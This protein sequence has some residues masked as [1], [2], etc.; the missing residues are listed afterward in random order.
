MQIIVSYRGVTHVHGFETGACLSRA[1]RRL[2][3][4]VYEYGKFYDYKLENPLELSLCKTMKW[5][6]IIWSIVYISLN[7]GLCICLEYATYGPL[8]GKEEHNS[9]EIIIIFEQ[10]VIVESG[11]YFARIFLQI[12]S[13]LAPW[14]R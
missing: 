10:F 14:L 3:H 4:S 13:H 12:S 6:I 1:L 2:G 9:Y 7:N 11:N 5:P 8:K